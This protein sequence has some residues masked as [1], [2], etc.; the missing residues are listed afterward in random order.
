M[1]NRSRMFF[2]VALIVL[3]IILLVAGITDAAHSAPAYPKPVVVAADA[4]HCTDP[5]PARVP[6]EKNTGLA[7]HVGTRQNYVIVRFKEPEFAL[8][9]MRFLLDDDQY[10]AR[11]HGLVI[12][13]DGTDTTPPCTKRWAK[14]AVEKL[15]SGHVYHG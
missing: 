11:R 7:C 1:S 5:T 13:P 9:F 8:P 12:I 10:F 6:G 2:G 15:G 4:L 14:N 3:G